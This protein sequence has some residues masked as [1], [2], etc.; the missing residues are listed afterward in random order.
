[1]NTP[2]DTPGDFD[3]SKLSPEDVRDKPNRWANWWSFFGV[4]YV[5]LLLSG[6]SMIADKWHIGTPGY[7]GLPQEAW[8]GGLLGVVMGGT[9]LVFLVLPHVRRREIDLALRVA[10]KRLPPLPPHTRFR[11][12]KAVL[13]LL[14]FGVIM[15]INMWLKLKDPR[16]DLV[17]GSVLIGFA[18]AGL[19]LHVYYVRIWRRAWQIIRQVKAK[20]AGEE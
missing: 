2:K 12:W 6:W 15:G 16:T 5:I 17:L 20:P 10:L 14:A 13:C 18:L 4:C 1:M 9:W 3:I 19:P 8:L 7:A 11:G